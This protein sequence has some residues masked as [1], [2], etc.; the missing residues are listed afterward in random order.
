MP[1]HVA[2]EVK[3]RI[4]VLFFQVGLEDLD[5]LTVLR[6]EG[7][8]IGKYTLIRLRFELGLKRRVCGVEAM[9]EA[10]RLVRRLV[11]EEL[12]KGVI[13]GYGRRYLATHF[14][15]NG[16]I[17][18]RYSLPLYYRINA[19]WIRDRLFRA[20]RTLNPE[21]VERRHRD[22][23]RHRGEYIVPGPNFI[24]SV[25]GYCKLKPYGIEIYAS[26]DA[27]SRYIIWVY[28]GISAA[29]AVSCLRQFCDTLDATN[30]QPRFVRSDRGTETVMLAGA[31]FQLQQAAEPGLRFEDCYL[32][33]TST[34]NQRIEAW[35][36]Q[37]SKGLLFRW[38]VRTP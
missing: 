29:T 6:D 38:R 1:P 9:Q 37:L 34:A 32:Y 26:V 11:T 35:W 8:K 33:G 36:Q 20:Y 27:Y 24:W 4:Q 23:Q 31:H 14:R 19:N 28:V 25:D 5:I 16:H 12:E 22:M 30:I 15:Q 7:F 17:V 10:D 2:D 21:A 3:A 13:D 18:A